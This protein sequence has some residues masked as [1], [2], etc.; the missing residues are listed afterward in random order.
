MLTQLLFSGHLK[1]LT[2]EEML[3]LLSVMINKINCAKSHQ[4]LETKISDNFWKACLSLEEETVKLIECEQK[5]GVAD[6]EKDPMKR[7]NY[8]F[9]ELVYKWAKKE[10]FV[11]I[12]GEFPNV[13]EGILIKMILEVKKLCKC[14]KEMCILIGDVTLAQ[15]MDT[16]ALLLEREIITT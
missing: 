13:E 4:M 10:T 14:V 11:K 15:R 8:Y 5:F 3:A 12:K 16:A 2:D 7:L 9:Y 6:E 1:Q